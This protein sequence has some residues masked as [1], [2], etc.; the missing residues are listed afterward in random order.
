MWVT[1]MIALINLN[2]I[3][4]SVI[5]FT[6]DAMLQTQIKYTLYGNITYLY[7]YYIMN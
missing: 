2:P 6:V 1:D 7:A 4:V 5:I 3:L